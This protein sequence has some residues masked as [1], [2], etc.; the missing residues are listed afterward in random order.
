MRVT[1]SFQDLQIRAD[2][3]ACLEAVSQTPE[4]GPIRDI[5]SCARTDLASY[6][7]LADLTSVEVAAADP[8]A[9]LF[10]P[11]TATLLL[12][13]IECETRRKSVLYNWDCFQD[14]YAKLAQ[15]LRGVIHVSFRWLGATVDSQLCQTTDQNAVLIALRSLLVAAPDRVLK[16]IAQSDRHTNWEEH[17]EPLKYAIRQQDCLFSD[18]YFGAEAVE[19]HAFDPEASHFDLATALLIINWLEN[20]HTHAFLDSRWQSFA[21]TYLTFKPKVRE[22]IVAGFRVAFEGEDSFGS[23]QPIHSSNQTPLTTLPLPLSADRFLLKDPE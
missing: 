22:P 18:A 15:P 6:G 12:S 2:L 19:L 10:G 4:H 7:T 8:T 11:A 5:A 9:P 3:Q 23:F 20:E 21:N 1:G 13:A 17:F 16:V 14:A